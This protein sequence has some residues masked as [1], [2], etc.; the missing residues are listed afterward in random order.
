LAIEGEQPDG[1][2][3]NLEVLKGSLKKKGTGMAKS[4]GLEKKD[5][6]TTTFA[7]AAGKGTARRPEAEEKYNKCIVAFAI[8]VNKGKDSKAAFDKKNCCCP[9]LSSKL[10][11]QAC[12]LFLHQRVGLQ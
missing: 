11:Q 7:E 10:H 8:R 9:I 2:E 12:R 5:K 1:V 4:K 6:K 3:V